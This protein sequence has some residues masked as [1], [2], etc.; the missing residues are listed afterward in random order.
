MAELIHQFLEP[1]VEDDSDTQYSVRIY[2]DHSG[3][4][5]HGWIE[6]YPLDAGD[7]RRTGRE[8]DQV[9]RHQLAFWAT[10]LS[11][12]YLEG[13]FDRAVPVDEQRAPSP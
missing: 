1:F 7:V 9:S 11:G 4:L 2:G 10:G 12:I 5:W 3:G 13:A 6:F 8:T